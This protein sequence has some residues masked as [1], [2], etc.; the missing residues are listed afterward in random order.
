MTDGEMALLRDLLANLDRALQN[1]IAETRES[2]AKMSAEISKV[3]ESLT[4]LRLWKAKVVGIS[5]FVA[6]LASFLTD[7]VRGLF[8]GR[9]P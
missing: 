7:W 9:I 5:G 1:H 8:H 2:R 3:N 6:F 4:D